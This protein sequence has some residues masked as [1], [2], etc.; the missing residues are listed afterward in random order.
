MARGSLKRNQKSFKMVKGIHNTNT[1]EYKYIFVT[2]KTKNDSYLSLVLQFK[3][4][5]MGIGHGWLIEFSNSDSI[6]SRGISD[7]LDSLL[8]AVIGWGAWLGQ[9]GASRAHCVPSFLC[10]GTFLK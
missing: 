5:F 6:S 3:I 2:N 7:L 1:K 8:P 4:L 10:K 9:F